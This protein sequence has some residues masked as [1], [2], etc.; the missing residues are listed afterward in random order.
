M[1]RKAKYIANDPEHGSTRI[2]RVFAWSPRQ[3]ADEIVWLE[4][5]EVFQVY[6]TYIFDAKIDGVAKKITAGKWTDVEERLMPAK[7]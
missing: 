2:K 4:F 5:F 6:V 3:I 1:R 7:K